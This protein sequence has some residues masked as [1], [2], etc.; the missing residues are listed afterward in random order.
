M[1]QILFN[2]VGNAVKFTE[3]G[4]VTVSA[5]LIEKKDDQ[6]LIS[7]VVEDTGIGI[8]E[9]QQQIIF[10]PFVQ[11][12]TN[13]TRKFGGTGLGLSIVKQLIELF[14]SA[15]Q[16]DSEEG[17]GTRIRFDLW[18][19]VI[20]VVTASAPVAK[21]NSDEQLSR[22]R[23]LLVEDNLMN[24][25]FMQQLFSR[26]QITAKIVENGQEAVDAVMDVDYDVVL[27][28]MHMPVM[29]GLEAT[30]QIRRLGDVQKSS[31]HIIALTASV[32][33]EVREK[34]IRNGMDDYLA[35]PFQLDVLRSK[36]LQ[37]AERLI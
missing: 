32:S 28:D 1:S 20:G 30:R 4:G 26:W 5:R 16:L 27:M 23:V 8:S 15:I 3:R 37:L 9:S 36:L 34:V 25:Y 13:T 21:T 24:I 7:F 22:L 11:A 10:D 31:I 14:G 12:S 17:K 35:K 18:I 33:D 2:L 6:H 29:D 19:K